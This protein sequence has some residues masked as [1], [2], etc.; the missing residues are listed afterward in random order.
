MHKGGQA[1]QLVSEKD[2]SMRRAM[3]SGPWGPLRAG[4]EG[5]LQW[6]C[7][8]AANSMGRAGAG[9]ALKDILNWDTEQGYLLPAMD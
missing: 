9:V 8:S 5:E 6:Y 3:V 1:G 4:E 2:I 7:K